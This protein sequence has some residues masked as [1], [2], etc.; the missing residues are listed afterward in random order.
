MIKKISNR[1]ILAYSMLIVLL[2]SFLLLF[3]NDLVRDTQL[4]ILKRE[5]KSKIDFVDLVMRERNGSFTLEKIRTKP[6]LLRELASII[7]LRITLIDDKGR[8]FADSKVEDVAKLDNHLYRIEIQEAR[9][10]TYG[11]S[12]RYSTTLKTDMLYF[13]KDMGGI[14]L[15]LA[16]PLFEI[17]ESL[18]KVRKLIVFSGIFV[19]FAAFVIIFYISRRITSPINDTLSFARDFS[20]G[21]YS[22]RIL[23]YRE[24]EIGS[25][26]RSLNR[27]ADTIVDKMDSLIFEQNKLEITLES[28]S[29]GIAV[30]DEHK[31]V[32]IANNAFHQLLD[33]RQAMKG[34]LYFEVIRSRALNTKIEYVLLRGEPAE[35]EEK[36]I[37]GVVCEVNLKPIKEHDMLQ[38]ILVVLHDVT[39]KKRIDQIKTELVG[40]MSHELKTPITIMKGY[41]E[42][43]SENIENTEL[44]T[45]F[46]QKALENADRQ[47]SIINDI[48]KLNLLEK[49]NDFLEEDINI[50]EVV[51]TCI[52]LL[53]VK[54][55]KRGI[56]INVTLDELD[57]EIKGSRFLAEEV[58]FNLIDNAVN[59]NRE[60]GFIHIK[61]EV[62]EDRRRILIEDTGIGI[63]PDSI[64]RIFERFYRV[65]KSR[66]RSTGGTGLGLSIVKHAA[67]LLGWN[68][69]VASG[70][71]G[72]VFAIEI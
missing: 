65:D 56:T 52:D 33:S 12:V 47:N 42:T 15:R 11:N 24:D 38:G 9:R 61:A 13:A 68:V 63:P 3:F 66:S 25:L 29:D 18:I 27:M 2:V 50:R 35:F 28:I 44:S 20:H 54:A 1:I 10:E 21:D 39:E 69:D 14:T 71:K 19:F 36:L 62:Q 30:I 70:K 53:N 26:Q 60:S 22:R 58:F 55:A 34:R 64:D 8:V 67:E 43:I 49:T 5:M 59:Y 32:H 23:N 41:L 40:N 37:S 51:T 48:L 45:E 31:R 16:K 57:M 6:S 46:I 17:D 4:T 72:T 7:T